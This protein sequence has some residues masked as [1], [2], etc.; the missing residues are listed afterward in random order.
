[1]YTMTYE[2]CLKENSIIYIDVR[3]KKEFE[4]STIPGAVNIPLFSNEEH[5]QVGTVY[6]KE[7]DAKA[8]MLAV[9]LVSPKIPQMLRKIKDLSTRYEKVVIFCARGGMRSKSLITFAELAGIKTYQ[10]TGGYK[11]YRHYILEELKDYKLKGKLL[12]LHG[13]TGVGKTELLYKLKEAGLPM[14]DLEGLANHR[15]SAFGS[16]GL[17]KPNNP[18]MFDSLLWEELEKYQDQEFIAIEAE[19]KRVGICVLPDFLLEAMEEGVHIL[20]QSSLECRSKRIVEE[21]KENYQNNKVEFIDR[22]IESLEIIKKHIIKSSG[23]EFYLNLI[24]LC[25]Q[26][27]F[28]ELVK[29]LLTDYYDP[30]YKYSQDKFESFALEINSDSMEQIKNKIVEFV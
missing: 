29:I 14:I 18:K 7:S 21:Y 8:R 3:T 17:G 30:L 1:M 23:K 6:T 10:L 22:A 13:F 19:S 20:I 16:I 4:E 12:V 5:A 15:G 11:A 26:G 27:R 28:Q 24:N 2:E 9:N 25:K